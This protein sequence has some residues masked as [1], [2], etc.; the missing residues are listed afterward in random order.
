M[1]YGHLLAGS[2]PTE[3]LQVGAEVRKG[4]YL[5]KVGFS[6]LTSHPHFHVHV[7]SRKFGAPTND[8]AKANMADAGVYRPMGFSTSWSL[9]AVKAANPNK[10][11]ASAWAALSNQSTPHEWSFVG[12][13]AAP[14]VFSLT[15][16][17]AATYQGIWHTG[18]GID[19]TVVRRGFAAFH[20]TFEKLNA[21]RFAL[22]AVEAF[23]EDGGTTFLGIFRRQTQV[24]QQTLI[25][26]SSWN[27]F[28]A[29][30]AARVGQGLELRDVATFTEAGTRWITGVFT[31]GPAGGKAM[32]ATGVAALVKQAE[33]LRKVKLELI[34]LDA[35]LPGPAA[36]PEILA[37]FAKSAEVSQVVQGVSQAAFDQKV[38]NACAFKTLRLVDAVSWPT[39]GG[40]REVVGILRPDAAKSGQVLG[41]HESLA[42][43]RRA[44][45]VHAVVGRRLAQV[46]V[47]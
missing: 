20:A 28:A 3:F 12:S 18:T 6:G 34:A 2:I 42:Q 1:V 46:C 15:R 30:A 10:A 45:E 14:P 13:G 47:Y 19:L 37:V 16:T 26:F 11:P 9:P 7:K 44:N 24:Q 38:K 32:Y 22:I 35:Y 21:D 36:Q 39:P 5:G 29:D 4:Q 27:T 23:E 31:A 43:L 40:G 25:R 8:P 33:I 41:T 17:D